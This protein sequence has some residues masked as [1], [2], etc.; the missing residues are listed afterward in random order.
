MLVNK[1]INNNFI[2]NTFNFKGKIIEIDKK[3]SEF[4]L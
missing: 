1:K 3:H 4:Y 2:N